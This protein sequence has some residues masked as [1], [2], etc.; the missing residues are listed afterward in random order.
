MPRRNTPTFLLVSPVHY[1]THS[2]LLLRIILPLFPLHLNYQN[3]RLAHQQTFI[4]ARRLSSTRKAA[5]SDEIII[6]GVR[7]THTSTPAELDQAG[8]PQCKLQHE[9]NYT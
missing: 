7:F 6:T 9:A 4:F 5:V 3:D 8:T 1:W 2:A